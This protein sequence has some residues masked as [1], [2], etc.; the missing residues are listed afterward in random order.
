MNEALRLRDRP[1]PTSA[2][3]CGRGR[4][5]GLRQPRRTCWR[6][7]HRGHARTRTRPVGQRPQGRRQGGAEEPRQRRQRTGSISFDDFKKGARALHPRLRRRARQGRP[8]RAAGRRSRRSSCSSPTSTPT[9]SARWCRFWTMGFNQHIRGTWVNEQCYM[10]HLLAGQAGAARATAPSRSPASRRACGTA[11]EVGTFSHRLPGRHGGGQ[12]D[13][14][15]AHREDLEAARR[16]RSTRKVGQ[17]HRGDHARP[18]GRQASSS[19]WVQ[20]TNPFQSIAQRQPLDRRRRARWT[21]SSSSPTATRRSPA[22][23]AD[24]ILPAAMIFE[25]WG[26][27]GNAERRTQLWRQQVTPPGEAAQRRLAD[28]RVL[29]ALHPRRGLEGAEDRRQDGPP[30]RPRQGEGDGIQGDEH[31]LRRPL[32]PQGGAGLRLARSGRE[33]LP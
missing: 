15:R 11:R 10:I 30:E 24:L 14:P 6:R 3:A 5:Y 9:R 18:R 27:Y 25:K 1:V 8:R 29:Q 32:R 23:V 2:T 31:P 4:Q 33:G 28:A 21:T 17:R 16:R 7:S 22:K 12:P 20:V 26:A 13:A 19:L